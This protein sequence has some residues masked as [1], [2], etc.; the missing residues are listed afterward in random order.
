MFIF[1]ICVMPVALAPRVNEWLA[2][3]LIGLAVAAHQAWSATTYASASDMFPERTIAALAGIG[4][5]V[6][7]LG[8]ILFPLFAGRMLDHYQLSPGGESAG[9]AILFTIC[10]SA[11]I[12]AFLVNHLLDSR[13][14]PVKI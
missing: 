10:G 5:A 9:Y 4:G 8:G 13:F 2:V 11:Y 3:F 1:S 14:E 7:S 12:V 6:G